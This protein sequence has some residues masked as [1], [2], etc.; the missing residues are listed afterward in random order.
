[1]DFGKKLKKARNEL[2]MT[3]KQLAKKIGIKRTTVAGYESEGKMPPYNTLIKIAQTL[4][5][6]LDYLLGYKEKDNL[7]KTEHLSPE[8]LCLAKKI[9]KRKEL[10]LLLKET[11][12]LNPDSVKRIIKII[13]L[14]KEEKNADS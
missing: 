7:D 6:S 5:C 14:I 1:M 12:D 9:S 4:N 3:Q 13:G 11:E 10:K 8:I 2:G